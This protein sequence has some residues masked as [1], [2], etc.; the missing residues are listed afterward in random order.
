MFARWISCEEKTVGTAALMRRDSSFPRRESRVGSSEKPLV[1][2]G[3]NGFGFVLSPS[4]PLFLSLFLS[5]T[6]SFTYAITRDQRDCWRKKKKPK[7]A[8]MENGSTAMTTETNRSAASARKGAEYSLDVFV[9]LSQSVAP[10]SHD[11]RRY[12]RFFMILRLEET[13]VWAA[14]KSCKRK[15]L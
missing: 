6:N 13:Q 12:R 15:Q 10:L 2:R 8:E 9:L 14:K 3:V 1:T 4:L 5:H 11:S 7:T